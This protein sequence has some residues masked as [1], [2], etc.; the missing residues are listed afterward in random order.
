MTMVMYYGLVEAL[1]LPQ[2]IACC[3]WF[4]VVRYTSP[5]LDH[6]VAGPNEPK[7]LSLVKS[8]K[9]CLMGMGK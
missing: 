1:N 7:I 4:F 9:K 5:L 2:C 8:E 3:S 6:C